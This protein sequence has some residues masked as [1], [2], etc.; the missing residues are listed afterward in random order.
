[1]SAA[2]T[3]CP[4][5]RADKASARH[6]W[7]ECKRFDALR[8]ELQAL[9]DLPPGWWALQPKCTSKTRWILT[10]AHPVALARVNMQIAACRLGIAIMLVLPCQDNFHR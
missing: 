8:A 4:F 2:A 6:F 1:M 7:Q 10:S 5:C 9:Y 3:C